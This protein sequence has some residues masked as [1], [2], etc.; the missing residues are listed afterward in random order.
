MENAWKLLG[1]TLGLLAAWWLDVTFIHFDT[2]A[3]W[4]VQAIKLV[5]GLA[6]TVA[7]KAGLKAPLIA[8]L[9]ADVGGAVRY[10]VMVLFAGA[11]WPMTFHPLCCALKKQIF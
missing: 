5:G 8:L 7:I 4:Y 10:A 11:V 1:A 2:R 3:V 9:G 6:L